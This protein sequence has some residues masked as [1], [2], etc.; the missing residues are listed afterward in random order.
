MPY[1]L[2]QVDKA[3]RKHRERQKDPV[4]VPLH[5]LYSLLWCLLK[6]VCQ[7]HN[8][9]RLQTQRRPYICP[10]HSLCSCRSFPSSQHCIHRRYCARSELQSVSAYHTTG[11]LIVRQS[12]TSQMHSPCT[13]LSWMNSQ[14][15][16]ISRLHNRSTRQTQHWVCICQPHKQCRHR[17][18]P[19]SQQCRYMR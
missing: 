1:C 18:L 4:S 9:S 12:C 10:P 11:T 16:N 5:T 17:S 7:L 15:P 6:N 2:H 3:Q 14:E 19:S 13:C 8:Q